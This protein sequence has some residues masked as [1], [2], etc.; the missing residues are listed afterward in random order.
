MKTLPQPIPNM[1]KFFRK[2]RERL[3]TENKFSKYLLYAI[4]EIALVVIGILIAL[5]INDWNE[6]KKNE[7]IIKNNTLLLIENLVADS[8]YIVNRRLAI[9][10]DLEVVYSIKKR[11]TR[12]NVKIDTLIK[13]ARDEYTAAVY[14]VNFTNQTVF[15]TILGSGEINLY[16]RELIQEIN[17]IYSAQEMTNFQYGNSFERYVE[18]LRDYR[19]RYTFNGPAN[20]VSEGPLFEKLWG[21]IDEV[22][23][24]AK[25][26]VMSGSKILVYSQTKRELSK[27]E[28]RIN[29][30]LPKLRKI[31][32]ND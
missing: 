18:A 8:V 24:I 12:P 6:N 3:L 5:Q 16:A 28:D 32:A 23:F 11:A 25:F 7:T 29:E 17:S 27:V 31:L 1:I 2:I 20:I 26:N 30:L 15:N 19:R 10:K 22:D 4:G 14:G 13:I 21:T 9:K